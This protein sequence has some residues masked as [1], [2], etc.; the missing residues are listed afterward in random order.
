MVKAVYLIHLHGQIHHA[1]HY[2]GATID[3]RNRLSR[4]A[5]GLGARLLEVAKDHK[6]KWVVSRIWIIPENVSPYIVEARLKKQRNGMKFCP[7][8]HFEPQRLLRL[9]DYPIELVNFPLSSE[10]FTDEIQR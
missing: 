2:M 10:G 1:K 9:D 5:A 3:L 6:I 7:K 8:C 4:H